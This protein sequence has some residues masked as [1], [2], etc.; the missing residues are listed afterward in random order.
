MKTYTAFAQEMWVASG[1]RAEIV[2]ALQ[3]MPGLPRADDLLVFDD[4]DGRQIDFDLRAPT[5]PEAPRGRG[6]PALGVVAREVTLLPRHWDWLNE[7]PGGASAALRKLVDAARKA[8]GHGPARRNAA[9][10]FLTSMAGDRPGYE[11]AIRALYADDRARFE[12]LAQ[13]WPR[14]V[15][16]HAIGLAWG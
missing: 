7:Q 13:P 12:A 5:E 8:E 3:A 11:E 10:R 14:A 6:R 16:D 15:R 4:D 9:Y 1:S 2:A